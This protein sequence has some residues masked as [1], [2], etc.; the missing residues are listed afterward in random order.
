MESETRTANGGHMPSLDRSQNAL[1][2]STMYTDSELP[3]QIGREAYSYRFV[4]RAF[5]PLLQRWGKVVEINRAESRLDYALMK[6]RHEHLRPLHLSFLPLHLTYLTH[7]APNIVFPFWEFPDIPNRSFNHSLRNNWV[8]VAE[9][10]DLLLTACTATR[11]AFVSAGVQ[12]PIRVVPV[13]IPNC[14]FQAADWRPDQKV[15][16]DCPAYVLP[17]PVATSPPA[18]P[19]AWEPARAD[20]LS[21]KARAKQAYKWYVKP[22]VPRALDRYMAL[23][24]RALAASRAAQ[25]AKE[26]ILMPLQPNLELSGIVYTTILNPFDLRKNWQDLLSALLLGLGERPDV[27]LVFKLVVCPELTPQAVN[28][29]L[30]FYH[31]LGL[32]HRC[33]VVFLPHYLSEEQMARL[34]EAST[35]YVNPA[36]AEGA[37]LPLQNFLAARRPGITPLHTAMLDYF[38]EE[39]G[40]LVESHPEPASWPHDPKGRISTRWHRLVWQSLH[41]QLRASYDTVRQNLSRYRAVAA[42]GR[43]RMQDYASQERVWP[44]LAAALDLAAESG[45]GRQGGPERRRIA[46]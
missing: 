19:S 3:S 33:K 20:G 40:F 16:L 8:H 26:V 31:Q 28:G 38:D 6:V 41:D 42:R 46:S 23:G 11:E 10:V 30:D 39:L 5:G 43:E 4:Q 37:C 32:D 27:T 7:Q 44:R 45:F 35:Y 18:E 17:G 13:P 34:A 2:V 9:H 12:T 29:M 25:K 22:R 15:V 21:W 24:V 36:R 1:V 14:Y